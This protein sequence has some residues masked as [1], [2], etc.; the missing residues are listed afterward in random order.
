MPPG[1]RLAVGS[2]LIEVTDQPHANCQKFAASFGLD[3]VK[4]VHSS[5]GQRLQ[6]R[7]VNARV[8]QSGAI[9][10]GDAVRKAPFHPGAID[11]DAL[12]QR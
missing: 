3:A 4:F 9:R 5:L 2:A 1:T 10:V 8:V 11:L 7:G 6:L 12:D